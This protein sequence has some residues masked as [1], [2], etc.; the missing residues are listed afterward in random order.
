MKRLLHITLLLM[1]LLGLV[2]QST[3]MAMV[4]TGVTASSSHEAT[5]ASMAG[6][7]CDDMSGAPAPDT[8]PCKNITLQ[9]IAAMGCSPLAVTLPAIEAPEIVTVE[10]GKSAPSVVT[11]L[12]GRSYGPEPDPPAILI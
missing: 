2:G 3:A 4:P 10:P 9:C 11:S 7:E 12:H 8:A 5:A 1:A 6:M